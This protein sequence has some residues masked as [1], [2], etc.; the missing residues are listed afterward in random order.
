MFCR[1]SIHSKKLF[2]WFSLHLGFAIFL[3]YLGVFCKY[4]GMSQPTALEI[5]PEI[6]VDC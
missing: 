2:L 1:Y 3:A 5:L 4:R 6:T